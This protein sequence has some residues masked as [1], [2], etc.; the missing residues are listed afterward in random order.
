MSIADFT[1]GDPVAFIVYAPDRALII[2]DPLKVERTVRTL[3]HGIEN[4]MIPYVETPT[5]LLK[6]TASLS[7]NQQ[8]A[9]QENLDALSEGVFELVVLAGSSISEYV[10]EIIRRA[11]IASIDMSVYAEEGSLLGRYLKLQPY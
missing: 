5:I 3:E 11:A 4:T 2:S 10:R 1:L 7:A 6:N 8:A 9:R